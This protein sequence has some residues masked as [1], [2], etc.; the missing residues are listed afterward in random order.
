MSEPIKAN[1]IKT[2]F[3][4]NIGQLMPNSVWKHD[5]DPGIEYQGWQCIRS[6]KAT[7][8]LVG[9]NLSIILRNLVATQY[10]PDFENKILFLE[11]TNE[12][13]VGDS[14]F[15]TLKLNG[16]FE[17]IKGVILGW[18]KSNEMRTSDIYRP[19]GD[20]LLECTEEY[21]FPI[22]EIGEIGHNIENYVIPIGIPITLESQ[23]KFLSI[24]SQTVK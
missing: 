21:S 24:D 22:L 23:K 5:L 7:G 11:A 13:G 18:F 4:G 9:G 2:F 14:M 20:I 12:I 1:I 15:T 6:G 17:K 19:I 16:V 3:E 10:S 8:K